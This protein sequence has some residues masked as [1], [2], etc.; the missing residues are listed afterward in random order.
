MSLRAYTL[1]SVSYLALASG[2]V[3]LV[4]HPPEYLLQKGA[5]GL[6]ARGR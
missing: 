6:D 5:G 3:M 2:S 4:P 1:H